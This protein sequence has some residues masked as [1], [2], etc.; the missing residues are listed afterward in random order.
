MK[1][2]LVTSDLTYCPRNYN[3]VFDFVVH[4]SSQHIAGVVL[5]KINK[6]GVLNKLLYLYFAG[7]KNIAST[8]VHNINDTLLGKKQKLLKKLEIP[9]ISVK[10]INDQET[11]LWLKNLEPDLIL[12]MRA[13]CVYEED[14]L[15]IPRLGCV[16]VHHGILPD[17]K[18]LFCDLYAIAHNRVTG[19]TIHQ[20]T[21]LIDQGQILHIEEM[22]KNKNYISYLR[23][24]VLKEKM[25]IVNFIK[26]VGQTDSLPQAI[27]KESCDL[28]VTT[29]PNLKT[30]K[31]LQRKGIIL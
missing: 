30:I 31:E 13:R 4:N 12:N 25:A 3:D 2:I 26:K 14:V 18:G 24:V 7:C 19:F 29:T 21:K 5:V 20:M 22:D 8:L 10:S 1:I 27:A 9:F 23:G 15:K 16:N 6:I 17:Q 11:I 28:V